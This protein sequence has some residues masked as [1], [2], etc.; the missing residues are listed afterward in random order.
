LSFEGDFDEKIDV[1]DLIIN[2]LKEH[3][4]KLDELV[5][6]LEEAQAT[7]APAR[8]PKKRKPVEGPPPAG[9]SVL[10]V[11]RRWTE[12]AERCS[13]AKLV[14]FDIEG[15]YFKVSAVANG[16][17]YTYNEAIPGMEISYRMV[18]GKAHVDSVDI[19]S[20]ELVPAA[21]RG[22]M[23]CGL[24]FKKRDVKVD[25]PDGS[26]VHRVVYEI[27]PGTARS[28][29]AY[30]LEVEEDSVVQGELKI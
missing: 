21:L 27:D 19:S 30:Q 3:E 10:A 16:V 14:A 25:M 2:V 26:S 15:G 18:E 22:K 29:L 17:I 20:A 8:Q 1:I 12:F 13:G 11:L 9:A 5:S 7:G 28:W 6:R 24:E 4:K 23:E